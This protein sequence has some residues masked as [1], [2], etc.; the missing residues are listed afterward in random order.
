[1]KL[2]SVGTKSGVDQFDYGKTLIEAIYHHSISHIRIFS[3]KSNLVAK[4][5]FV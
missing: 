5:I 1:M 2:R 3:D 4:S